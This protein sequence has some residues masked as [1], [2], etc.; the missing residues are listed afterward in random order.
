MSDYRSNEAGM[1]YDQEYFSGTQATIYIGDVWVDE[2]TSFAFQVTQ[3]KAPLYGYASQ[4]FDAVSRGPRLVRGQ[5][6]IN[7]KEAGYLWLVLERYKSIRGIKTPFVKTGARNPRLSRANIERVT[8]GTK[9]TG[10]EGLPEQLS[11]MS[12]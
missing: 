1:V 3:A 8:Q 10:M 2:V 5:F 7:F 11:K 12:E 4:L 6:T 9:S